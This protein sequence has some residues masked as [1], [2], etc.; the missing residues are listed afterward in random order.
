MILEK[1]RRDIVPLYRQNSL[2]LRREAKGEP[3]SPP[4]HKSQAHQITTDIDLFTNSEAILISFF[5]GGGFQKSFLSTRY[6]KTSRIECILFVV[7]I[8]EFT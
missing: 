2:S 7:S 5:L 6:Q 3:P 4:S 8:K 1:Q